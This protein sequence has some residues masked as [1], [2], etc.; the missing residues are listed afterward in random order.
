V[1]AV[2]LTLYM[3]SCPRS[4]SL[5]LETAIDGP[6]PAAAA[7]V[8][9]L[10]HGRGGSTSQSSKLVQRL[11]D[12]GLPADVSIVL[13]EG[14]FPTLFGRAW[15]DDENEQATSRARVRV[16]LAELLGAHGPI[17][18]RV[19]L[20]GFSQGAGVAGDVAVEEPRVGALASFSPCG[21][22]LR[23][24]LPKRA[25]L[26]VLLAHGNR[27][28]VCPVSE[29]RSLAAML[30]DAQVPVQYLE[31]DGEHTVP[32]EVIRALVVFATATR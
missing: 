11:R 12:A 21:F 20:A 19:V 7:G 24:Q 9:V 4:T 8:L 15:G 30:K 25:H 10:L 32:A 26:R 31:F 29:S 27:D 28:A 1:A 23:G 16:R 6:A 14:P 18:T 5:P 22:W 2:T 13:I 17:P 3:R